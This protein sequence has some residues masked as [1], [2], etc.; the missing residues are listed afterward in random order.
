ML[1]DFIANL[2]NDNLV[3]P[4]RFR[5]RITGSLNDVTSASYDIM[6]N[7]ASVSI[8]ALNLVTTGDKRVG[9]GQ[10]Q[11]FVGGKELSPIVMTFYE[12][13]S[14]KERKFFS[15]WIDIIYNKSTKKFNFFKNYAK[16]VTIEQLSKDGRVLYQCKLIDAFPTNVSE[17]NRSYAA[18]DTYEQFSVNMNYN[19]IQEI[20][21]NKSGQPI[22]DQAELIGDIE[23][24]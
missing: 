3:S 22:L 8:P 9:L 18:M 6:L 2:K 5:V 14:F 1:Q 11:N 24:I 15:D 7:C 4:A 20:F 17:M 23:L 12:S 19:E 16:I 13:E 21:Y 10:V